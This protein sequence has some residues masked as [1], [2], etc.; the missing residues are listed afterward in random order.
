MSLGY[1]VYSKG[2]KRWL[3]MERMTGMVE[4]MG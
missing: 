4:D 1:M 2:I 3:G